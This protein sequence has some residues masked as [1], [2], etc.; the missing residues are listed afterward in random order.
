MFP[1][2]PRLLR[3]QF[4][5]YQDVANEIDHR[6]I[7]TS[8]VSQGIGIFLL[9]LGK[10]VLIANNIGAL[11]TTIKATD[12]SQLSTLT[13]WLGILAFT[14]Q[15]YFDFSGYSDMA[16]GLGKM[17]GFEFP[18]NFNYPYLS[19]SISEFAA[20]GY[21]AWHLVPMLCLYSVGRQPKRQ[22]CHTAKF[23]DRLVFDRF[24][25]RSKLELHCLGIVFR[26][27][28]YYGAV[29]PG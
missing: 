7:T 20:D 5:R 14:F 19:R 25:A 28:D 11:W 26:Y 23:T 18:Q 27:F 22:T 29:I 10:K 24:M 4:V 9:G 21:Y 1:C 17:L 6:T 15:I 8:K 13:A 2:F 16:V 12:I 3:D